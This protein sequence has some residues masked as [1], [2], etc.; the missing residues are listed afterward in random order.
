[1][2]K[3][4]QSELMTIKMLKWRNSSVVSSIY[5]INIFLLSNI[6]DVVVLKESESLI[7][8]QCFI[9]KQKLFRIVDRCKLKFNF[10]KNK[11]N[12]IIYAILKI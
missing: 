6:D 3:F 4:N 5:Y 8:K 9:E 2:I 12:V 7:Q 11:S 10:S 1:M